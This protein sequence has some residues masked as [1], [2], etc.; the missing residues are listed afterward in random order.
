[1]FKLGEVI[2]DWLNLVFGFYNNQV[3]VIF[4]LLG[5]SPTA[6][7]SGGP[8]KVIENIEP[9]FIA[10]GSSLVVLFFVIGFC[11]ESIN[12]RD[13]MRFENILRMLIRLVISQW[14][15]I[16]NI[17]FMKALFLSVGNLVGLLGSSSTS[18]LVIA[19]AQADII[20]DLGFGQSILFLIL[21]V[22]LSLVIIVCGFFM[23]Y[24]VYFRFL[25]ILLVVPLGA[26][27]Y[28]TLGSSQGISQTSLQYTKHFI[29]I[30]LEAV[31]MVLAIL[32]CNAFINSGLPSFSGSYAQW[33]QVLM[34]LLEMTFTVCITAGAVKGA[35]NV[36]AKA[37]GL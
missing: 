18:E 1:M 31:T 17:T 24:T 22:L 10:V 32:V 15:V 30:V 7:K 16:N 11:S 3:G 12:I 13:E 37:L 2:L 6:F 23:L 27:A 26:L 33:A 8:W 34:Y 35:Q 4:S 20:R 21:A 5:E 29:S 14:L 9:I 28:S 36:T 19:S 25:R